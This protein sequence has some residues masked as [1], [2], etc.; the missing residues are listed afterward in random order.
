M[1]KW[2]ALS[3]FVVFAYDIAL[4]GIC[5]DCGPDASTQQ[6]CIPCVGDAHGLNPPQVTV[7]KA[8]DLKVP[9]VVSNG[10][11]PSELLLDESLFHPPILAA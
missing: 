9:Y 5:A 7:Q 1:R 4:D 3:F 2:L 11:E 6:A 10:A 8:P